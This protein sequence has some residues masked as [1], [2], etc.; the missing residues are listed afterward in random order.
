MLVMLGGWRVPEKR[1][2]SI[3]NSSL[4]TARL[5][6]EDLLQGFL[7]RMMKGLGWLM[8]SLGGGMAGLEHGTDSERRVI[9]ILLFFNN[10]V[11]LLYLHGAF[12]RRCSMD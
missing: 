6:R 10:K 4:L 5:R 12:A 7:L 2:R 1:P 11:L 8:M 9:I 3:W